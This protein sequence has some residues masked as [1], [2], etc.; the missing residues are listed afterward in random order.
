MM[1]GRYDRRSARF[2][3]KQMSIYPRLIGGAVALGLLLAA[4]L[5]PTPARATMTTIDLSAYVNTNPSINA[6]TYPTGTSTGNQ[7]TGIPFDIAQYGANNYAGSWLAGGTGSSL[8]IPLAVT[9]QASFY[10]LLNNYYG[11][12]GAVE[13]TITIS[14][15]NNGDFIWD[16]IGGVDT[17]DYNNN[18]FTNTL[19]PTTLVWFDNSIGQ[20]FD[21]RQFNLP[22][23]AATDTVTK[24]TI[25]QVNYKDSALFSGLTFST[26]VATVPEPASLALLAVALAGLGLRRRR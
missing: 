10:A 22:S 15:Q 21:L 17:R 18:T 11:T 8:T 16:A 5:H 14:T 4:A 13:Y 2:E 6:N 1:V 7:G 12:A 24:F 25:T 3:E 26:E 19:A 20:R 9:G 23:A